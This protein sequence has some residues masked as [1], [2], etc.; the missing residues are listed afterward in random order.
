MSKYFSLQLSRGGGPAR[1]VQPDGGTIQRVSPLTCLP[2]PKYFVF[3]SNGLHTVEPFFFGFL[4]SRHGNAQPPHVSTG[5]P[6]CCLY[7]APDF[8][9]FFALKKIPPKPVTRGFFIPRNKPKKPRSAEAFVTILRQGLT[10]DHEPGKARRGGTHLRVGGGS[11][12]HL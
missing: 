9:G 1:R 4:A 3:E 5:S 12:R 8:V 7:Q 6:R 10:A 11:H 2:G